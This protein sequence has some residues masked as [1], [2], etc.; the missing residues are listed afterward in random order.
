MLYII[1]YR[2]VSKILET[3]RYYSNDF[4]NICFSISY[5]FLI[6]LHY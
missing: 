5:L 4:R 1:E 2:I 3:V 6:I